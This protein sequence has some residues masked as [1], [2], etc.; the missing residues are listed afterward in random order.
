MLASISKRVLDKPARVA[1]CQSNTSKGT[2]WRRH[3]SRRALVH[4]GKRPHRRCRCQ[5]R[6]DVSIISYKLLA[7]KK[8]ATT[9]ARSTTASWPHATRRARCGVYNVHTY[10]IRLA[11]RQT[12]DRRRPTAPG[13][14]RRAASL[15]EDD[16][17]PWSAALADWVQ[18]HEW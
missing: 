5:Y 2:Y 11:G 3:D 13:T 12:R 10:I 8:P 16:L 15:L 9:Q 6:T 4:S 7:S 1:E 17:H 14:V 18:E